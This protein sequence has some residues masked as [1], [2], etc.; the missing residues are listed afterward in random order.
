MFLVCCVYCLRFAIVLLT[1]QMYITGSTNWP[2]HSV[3]KEHLGVHMAPY[4]FHQR[5]WSIS[6]SDG[7]VRFVIH[8]WIAEG[9]ILNNVQ[10]NMSEWWKAGCLYMR[11]KAAGLEIDSKSL[12]RCVWCCWLMFS[13]LFV[14]FSFI[15]IVELYF[16]VVTLGVPTIYLMLQLVQIVWLLFVDKHRLI[17][18]F[19]GGLLVSSWL[20]SA[21]GDGL[22]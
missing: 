4:C 3:R 6:I 12:L 16:I 21:V 20:A 10:G 5:Q 11:R 13:V 1:I 15:F 17:I 7:W 18:A 2:I 9:R 19:F 8:I 22:K 14:L